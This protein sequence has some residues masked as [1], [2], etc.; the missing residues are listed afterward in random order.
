MA[1]G[2]YAVVA[3]VAA[4]HRLDDLLDCL[5]AIINLARLIIRGKTGIDNGMD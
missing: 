3:R 2:T 4:R 1:S 5:Y